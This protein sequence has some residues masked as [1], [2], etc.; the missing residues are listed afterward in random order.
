MTVIVQAAATI[1]AMGAMVARQNAATGIGLGKCLHLMERE[2]KA[3][4]SLGSHAPGE[5]TGSAPGEPPDLVTGDLRRSVQTD[6]PRQ[7]TTSSW[8]GE[9]GPTTEYARIQELGGVAGHGVVLPARPY[10]AP[11]L[12]KMQPAMLAVMRAE[13]AGALGG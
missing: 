12:E 9:V 4:L 7:E 5:P 6:G 2:I 10:V 11:T 8:S 13:W 1:R 3:E